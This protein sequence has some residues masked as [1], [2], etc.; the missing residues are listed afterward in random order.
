MY[1]R[2]YIESLFDLK[3]LI[4]VPLWMKLLAFILLFSL[5]HVHANSFGQKV[6][7][8]VKNALLVDV[9]DEIH[10]Q[11]GLDFLYNGK[12]L[13]NEKRISVTAKGEHLHNLLN[14]ILSER[15]LSYE[16]KNNTVLITRSIFSDLKLANKL[17]QNAQRKT[18]TGKVTD[19]E[20]KALPGVSIFLKGTNIGTSSDE[21]GY[22]KMELD[23]SKGVLVFSLVGFI[24]KEVILSNN[25]ILQV[26]LEVNV[27]SLDETVVVAFGKQ[28]K[29][30][31]IGAITTVSPNDLKMPVAKISTSLAG[32]M[33]GIVTVQGSGEPGNGASFW[34]RGVSS[35]GAN[36]RPLILVDGIERS[37]DLVDPEDVESFSI[38]KDATA[39]AVYGVRGANGIVL[40]TTKR[41]KKSDKPTID[42]R[43]EIGTLAPTKVPKLANASQWID[44]Y[45]DV[46]FEAS[47]RIPFPQDLKDLYVNKTD[48]DL[49]PNVDWMSELF[50]DF[51]TSNRLNLNVTGGGDVVRYYVSGSYLAENGIF[52]P[53]KTPNYDP[54]VN[55]SKINFRSNLDIRLSS[56][57]ELSLNL[58]NQYETKNRLGVDMA[59]MYEMALHTTPIAIPT[60]YSD[61]THAQPLVGQNPYYALNS[62]GYSEDFWNNAQ[63][64]VSL[65]Q[66]FSELVTNGLKGNIKFSWDAFNG[67]TLDKRK[68]PATYYATGRDEDGN[69]ILHKN[70]DGSDYLSLARSNRGERT[71][72]LEASLF[73]DNLF[74]EKHRVGGLV[75]FSMRQRTNNFPGDYIAAFPFRN[76]GVASRATYSYDDKY[77]IEGNFGYNG[78]EN[79]SPAKRFGFFPSVALGYIM[80]NE[81]YFEPLQ[82]VVNFLKLRGSMGEIGNDQ[83]GGDRR[84]AYNS[85]MAWTSGYHFGS[86]GQ[87]WRDGIATGHPGNPNVSWESAVKKNAGLELG[88]FNKIMINADYFY[89]KRD[90]IYILQE[91][92]P[93][94]VGVNVKQYVNLGRMINRGVDASME[95][96]HQQGDFMIQGRGNFTYNRNKKLYDDRPTPIWAY[97]SEVG[98]RLYQQNGLISL[99]LFESEQE[100]AESPTQK[101]GAVRPGDIKYKDING[102]G[103][104]D[105]YDRVAIGHAYIPEINYGFGTSIGYKGFDVSAFF[106]GVGNVTRIIGGGP[107]YGQSGS[108]LVYGQI[109][110][111][112]ADE[113]WTEQNPNPNA[114]YPRLSMI[115]NSNNSQG[116]TFWQKNMSF[117]RLKNA[118]VGYTLP[119][120]LVKRYKLSKVRIYAQ[121]VNL[122]TLSKFK[123]WDP[124]LDT[125]YGGV[126]PQMRVVNFGLNIIL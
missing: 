104:I 78:S 24:S 60:Q 46:N 42:L 27:S 64:L 101:F 105:S 111:D 5:V 57:T 55:Y 2:N 72:N 10:K 59:K 68:N 39:T 45:N 80:S 11:T 3:K 116:S 36:N 123:I 79:F 41:G 126:Y 95:I 117:L 77:F 21:N 61:G 26:Q 67:S 92:V 48:L 84:F 1:K 100:I 31:V 94:V 71:T 52:K 33:A 22:F 87:Q 96:T 73:Y 65:T 30:S 18:I 108:I 38:L 19:P 74:A 88:L 17:E 44:Y 47:G 110:S 76:I 112:V 91:S 99:G 53:Q 120:D 29:A 58:S 8:E 35:F 115:E 62:T 7:I 4:K 34:I 15:N 125:S 23:D 50:K 14:Q 118:E 85:E 114:E 70:A 107:L 124:E 40:V 86:T 63:S 106:H 69:L 54:S 81:E 89:E 97:Q 32:Q 90:G 103:V 102:D 66:D 28:R 6:S 49:Y 16:I 37:L 9:L 75:L 25:L 13:R 113:R 82:P 51:T 83:I 12:L 119:T 20:G 56:S 121:G 122:F 109:Y 98:K 43:A 93:S